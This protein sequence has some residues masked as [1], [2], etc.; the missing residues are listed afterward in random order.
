MKGFEKMTTQELEELQT[1]KGRLRRCSQLVECFRNDVESLRDCKGAGPVV[2]G[3]NK[4]IREYEDKIVE[5]QEQRAQIIQ[6]IMELP[7]QQNRILLLR[8]DLGMTYQQ[9]ADALHMSVRYVYRL[10]R[11]SIDE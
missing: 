1:I 10:R 3:I 8:Y 11:E 2:S 6:K 5:L 7:E 4:A 9:I